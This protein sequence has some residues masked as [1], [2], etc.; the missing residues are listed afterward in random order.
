MIPN[1][2]NE[3]VASEIEY[4]DVLTKQI[5]Q[6]YEAFYQSYGLPNYQQCATSRLDEDQRELGQLRAIEDLL[7][8]QMSDF[9]KH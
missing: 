3:Q 4:S 2:L 1:H 9:P 8:I 7:S 6:Y 5:I